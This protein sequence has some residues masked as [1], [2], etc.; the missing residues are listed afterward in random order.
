M[1]TIN[2]WCIS[3]SVC[4]VISDYVV[5]DW[6]DSGTEAYTDYWYYFKYYLLF[7]VLLIFFLVGRIR[8]SL[9][10]G[11]TAVK[12]LHQDMVTAVLGAPINNYYD[13]TPIGVSLNRFSRDLGVLE[14]MLPFQTQQLFYN[15]WLLLKVIII[16]CWNLPWMIAVLF[17]VL[18]F[19]HRIQRYSVVAANEMNRICSAARSPI[20]ANIQEA[21]DGSSTIRA[22]G[23]VDY[24]I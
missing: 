1:V 7:T 21:V 8:V 17:F 5:G 3:Y 23:L 2:M 15:W 18:I 13:I 9:Y 19:I 11:V 24:S 14:N 20:V 16:T 10:T 6:A 22:Y 12:L 4:K